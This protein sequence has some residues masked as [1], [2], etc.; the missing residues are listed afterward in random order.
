MLEHGRVNTRVNNLDLG[1]AAQAFGFL[2][3]ASILNLNSLLAGELEDISNTFNYARLTTLYPI[4][5]YTGR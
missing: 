3:S 2:S 1:N 5:N 4:S